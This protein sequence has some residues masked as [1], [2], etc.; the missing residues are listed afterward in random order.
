MSGFSWYY[1]FAVLLPLAALLAIFNYRRRRQAIL[2]AANQNPAGGYTIRP[3]DYNR[4]VTPD[5]NPVLA[6]N[7]GYNQPPPAYDTVDVNNTETVGQP[8]ETPAD[9]PP[10]YY[11]LYKDDY[12]KT[13][14]GLSPVN[15]S[16]QTSI[17]DAQENSEDTNRNEAGNS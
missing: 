11:E 2:R 10:S 1:V 8:Q 14:E 9:A 3:T 13:D 6:T 4:L 17:S 15:T 12:V 5:P 16:E 7:A